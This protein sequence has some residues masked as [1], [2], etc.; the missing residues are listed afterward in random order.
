[1]LNRK[2]VGDAL[3]LGIGK[4]SFDDILGI[5]NLRGEGVQVVLSI[6]VKVDAVI[7][8]GFHVCLAS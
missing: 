7:A 5:L 2:I 4:G 1:M 3:A 8:E 6:K